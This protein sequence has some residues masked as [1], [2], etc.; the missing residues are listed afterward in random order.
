MPSDLTLHKSSFGSRQ[1]ATRAIFLVAGY[2]RASWAPL[3]PFVKA[4]VGL[5]DGQLGLL[6]LCLGAGSMVAMPFAGGLTS[7]FGCRTV[8]TI[9][10]VLL[11]ATLPA[12]AFVHDV[13]SAIFALTFFGMAAGV[14]DVAMNIQAIEVERNC[15]RSIMSGFHAFYSI[16]GIV[17]AAGGSLLL[18]VG[19]SH[20]GS[21]AFAA[22]LMV[23]A[24]FYA[25][26]ALIAEPQAGQASVFAIPHGIVLILSVFTF[27]VF[28][29][30]SAVLD[31]SGVFLTSE[32]GMS[33]AYAGY[34]YAAFAVLMTM[35]RLTGDRVV[36][37]LGKTRVVVAGSLCA[38]T[39]FL[40]VSFTT[41][42]VVDLFG[43]ALVGAGC[44][45]IAPV[46]FSS[47]GKQKIMP[48]STAVAAMTTIGYCGVF[49][50]PV[51]IGALAHYTSLASA[52]LGLVVLLTIIAASARA[53]LRDA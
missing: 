11:C 51:L 32:R 36:N 33:H 48:T 15:G 25:Y 22:A 39:G 4:R 3:V 35:G 47:V 18:T 26:P 2:G 45:N 5:D 21:T 53:V 52:L 12:L 30:E 40:V 10:T 42:W 20:G 38:A 41:S 34:G 50:G 43:Y 6:L 9:A 37:R 49:V 1:A 13:L 24:L 7:R 27:I 16:G 14:V 31:W 8:I 17:G 29:T 23:V 28:L 46:L 19:L 44:S